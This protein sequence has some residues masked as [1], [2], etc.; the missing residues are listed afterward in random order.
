[1]DMEKNL[2]MYFEHQVDTIEK[3]ID[4]SGMNIEK[5][6]MVRKTSSSIKFAIAIFVFLG[7]TSTSIVYGGEIVSFIKNMDLFKADGEL[8]WS[9]DTE[10]SGTY[11]D[12]AN[13]AYEQLNLTQG[14][15]V[16]IYVEDDNPQNII[17]SQQ[18]PLTTRDI[19]ELNTYQL[20]S[21][22]YAFMPELLHKYEFAEGAVTYNTPIP[23]D[24]FELMQQEARKTGESVIIKEIEASDEIVSIKA[25]YFQKEQIEGIP[26]FTVFLV[27]WP[28]DKIIQTQEE[29][30]MVDEY[31]KIM[32][33][34]SEILYK[35][36]SDQKEITW[37]SNGYYYN[38][39]SK[40]ELMTKEELL[41]ITNALGLK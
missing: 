2:K 40:Q 10:E 8:A 21:L 18:E 6:N 9:I 7:M 23:T 33:D 28:G 29:D 19:N 16:A 24:Y 31:E 20:D 22:D 32:L 30:G 39:S 14:Q 11:Q 26:G 36:T 27:K 35:A 41:E 13:D 1:M 34:N 3:D 4:L 17:V 38:I 25:D 15:A 37:V 5:A 12:V